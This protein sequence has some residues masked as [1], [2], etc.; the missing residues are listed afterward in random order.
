MSLG[1]VRFVVVRHGETEWAKARRHTSRTDLD[2]TAVGVDVAQK[3]AGVL[4]AHE[5]AHGRFSAVWSSPRLRARRTADLAG[6]GDRVTTNDD[7]VEWFY[8]DDEGR[9]TAEI[10]VDHPG[11]HLWHDGPHN[12]E[13][14]AEASVRVDR[15]IERALQF[16]EGDILIFAHGHILDILAARWV[17]LSGAQG[18][19]FQLDPATV[20]ILGWHRDDRVI[21]RW[22]SPT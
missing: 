16:S 13:S 8:G 11:W 20:S 15:V 3:L 4:D 2:L 6:F 9:T 10:L 14:I 18:R 1:R 7:L 5:A 17:G 22:N 19:L 21:Q 12:G